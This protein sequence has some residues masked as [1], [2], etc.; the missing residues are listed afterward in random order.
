MKNQTH[1]HSSPALVHPILPPPLLRSRQGPLA[2]KGWR[3][4]LPPI[5]HRNPRLYCLRHNRLQNR[6]LP[7]V[8]LVRMDDYNH[9]RWPYDPP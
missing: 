7:L 4:H 1:E 5:L 6:P 3:R 2:H 8:P 9:W